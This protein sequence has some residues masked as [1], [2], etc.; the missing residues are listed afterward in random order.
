MLFGFLWCSVRIKPK[1]ISTQGLYGIFFQHSTFATPQ[2]FDVCRWCTGASK[3][4]ALNPLEVNKIGS[5]C[6]QLDLVLSSD[7]L[8]KCLSTSSWHYPTSTNPWT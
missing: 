4:L 3:T 1:T 7:F 8:G 6:R 2:L 5:Y